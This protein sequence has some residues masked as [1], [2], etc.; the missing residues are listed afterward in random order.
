MNL[1]C[2]SQCWTFRLSRMNI[3]S[4]WEAA[5]TVDHLYLYWVWSGP[6]TAICKVSSSHT[7]WQCSKTKPSNMASQ[8]NFRARVRALFALESDINKKFAS[9]VTVASLFCATSKLLTARTPSSS[10]RFINPSCPVITSTEVDV[11]PCV[12]VSHVTTQLK[13]A[14]L[15]KPVT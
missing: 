8:D 15:L 10:C 1:F 12:F 2:G 5:V 4:V 9:E 13:N 6:Q 3:N 7:T 14:L 11:I